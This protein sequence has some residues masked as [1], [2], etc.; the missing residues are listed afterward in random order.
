MTTQIFSMNLALR[1]LNQYFT[2]S[3]VALKKITLSS[4]LQQQELQGL[5][6]TKDNRKK[7][8]QTCC[9]MTNYDKLLGLPT[10]HH[11]AIP[12]IPYRSHHMPS[13]SHDMLLCNHNASTSGHLLTPRCGIVATR[14]GTFTSS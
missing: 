1:L 3:A 7:Q 8:T 11:L 13:L 14:D 12:S 6:N 4:D 9:L 10:W 2:L 5:Q